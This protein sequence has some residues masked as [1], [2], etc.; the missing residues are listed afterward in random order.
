MADID[1]CYTIGCTNGGT[2][3]CTQ[4]HLV[5]YCSK[6]CQRKDWKMKKRSNGVGLDG[7]KVTCSKYYQKLNQQCKEQ[8]ADHQVDSTSQGNTRIPDGIM[9]IIELKQG[10]YPWNLII[11]NYPKM[12]RLFVKGILDMGCIFVDTE[13]DTKRRL[14]VDIYDDDNEFNEY[15]RK[16]IVLSYIIN[17]TT[18]LA[19]NRR[20]H[21]INKTING[22]K[23]PKDCY[24]CGKYDSKS[25]NN[26]LF[27]GDYMP[28]INVGATKLLCKECYELYGTQ[29]FYPDEIRWKLIGT[30]PNVFNDRKDDDLPE[31]FKE[32]LE[33]AA[34]MMDD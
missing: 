33:Y 25:P 8:E 14:T 13:D 16:E 28:D 3:R 27:E 9:C 4:C 17:W 11:D 23:M 30:D 18:E 5:R 34:T 6:E 19:S 1:Y 2:L 22:P 29:T 15:Q 26:P 10:R 31:S 20:F 24:K 7:H 12:A 32:I 21:I